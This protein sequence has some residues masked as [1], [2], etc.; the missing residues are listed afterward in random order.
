MEIN[1]KTV[2]FNLMTFQNHFERARCR[3]KGAMGLW[4]H[5]WYGITISLSFFLF[6]WYWDGI[7]KVSC[8][9]KAK[10]VSY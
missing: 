2:L 1:S 9:A 7:G 5:Y 4:Y 8:Q 3:N 10:F 6:I